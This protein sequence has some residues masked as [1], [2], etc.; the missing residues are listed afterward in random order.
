MT[1]IA[2]T[3]APRSVVGSV[4]LGATISAYQSARERM[5][6]LRTKRLRNASLPAPFLPRGLDDDAAL[7]VLADFRHAR[8]ELRAVVV[9]IV[10]TS[11]RVGLT[12]ADVIARVAGD[13]ESLG[14]RGIIEYDVSTADE[15][16][17][18][19][20]ELYPSDLAAD[21][22]GSRPRAMRRDVL[23]FTMPGELAG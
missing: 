14:D 2:I 8:A 18:W 15:I 23:P 22:R 10:V 6:A 7:R 9:E 16:I 19:I 1:S 13:I 3:P 5:E 11:A 12:K 20:V 21:S 4:T 17:G